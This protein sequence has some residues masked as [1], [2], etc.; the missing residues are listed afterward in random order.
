MERLSLSQKKGQVSGLAPAIIALLIAGVFLVMGVII[1]QELRD[2]DTLISSSETV[3]NE[4]GAW[5]NATA[6]PLDDEDGDK[7]GGFSVTAAANATNNGTGGY[8]VIGSGN[9]T[10][11]ATLGTVTGT[12]GRTD[13][14]SDVNITYTYSSGE[15][16]WDATNSSLFGISTFADFWEIIVIAIITTLVMGLLLFAFGRRTGR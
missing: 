12:A 10:V 16:A 6:Y 9:Y 8:W 1:L 4:T 7:T 5:I 13:N 2:L 15:E 14:Y 3:T 11:D